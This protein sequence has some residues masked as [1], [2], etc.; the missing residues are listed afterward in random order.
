[1]LEI[2]DEELRFGLDFTKDHDRILRQFVQAQG[3]RIG[4]AK[5]LGASA[6]S[7]PYAVVA[8]LLL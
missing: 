4:H 5:F 8:E 2:T 6:R 1:M 7:G 3:L